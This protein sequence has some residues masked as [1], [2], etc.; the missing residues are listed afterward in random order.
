MHLLNT[1][2]Y[3]LKDFPPDMVPLY[4]ILSHTWNE[5]EISF[6]DITE[7]LDASRLRKGFAKIEGCCKFARS[8]EFEWVWIDTCA[9]D[10][11]SSAELS[12]AINNM[13]GWYAGS[14][15][16]YVYLED[17]LSEMEIETTSEFLVQETMISNSRWFQRGWTLQE[18]LAPKHLVFL[19][20]EWNE[21]GVCCPVPNDISPDDEQLWDKVRDFCWLL[22]DATGIPE[23]VVRDPRT[24]HYFSVAQRMSWASNRQTTRSED[25]AYSLMGLFNINMPVIYGE[26]LQKAFRRLQLEIMQTT[27][28]HSLFA[29]SRAKR[30]LSGLVASSPDDFKFSNCR[31]DSSIQITLSPFSMTNLGLSISLPLETLPDSESNRVY[32]AHLGCIWAGRATNET[33]NVYIYLYRHSTVITQRTGPVNVYQRLLDS[34]KT[35]ELD[36]I[37][38]ASDPPLTDIMVPDDEQVRHLSM[39]Y[40]I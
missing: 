12:E 26:G 31:H 5:E 36:Q 7:N 10:K 13:Y 16:C 17:V 2:T 32:R 3:E 34:D 24:I 19:D 11:K 30:S 39:M 9:I 6:Q 18:L 8:D 40:H 29:W 15:K 20:R 1:T 23:V 21:I 25:R 27:H 28:D 14:Q 38:A 33:S 22:A 37:P 35:F 4:A